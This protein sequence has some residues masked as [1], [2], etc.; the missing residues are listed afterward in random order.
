MS[1]VITGIDSSTAVTLPNPQFGDSDAIKLNTKLKITMSGKFYT[2][3][4]SPNNSRVLLK[5]S[6]LTP[7]QV[8]D[9]I[10]ALEDW[11]NEEV[12]IDS[13]N[14]IKYRGILLS[15]TFEIATTNL[16]CANQ[17]DSSG[18]DTEFVL[19]TVS[20]QFEGVAGVT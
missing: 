5:F 12:E 6:N 16:R 13:V 14:G 9:F 11:G 19:H 15:D 20:I 2:C 4:N 8:A 18:R 17:V 10:A 7:I 3:I 1:V